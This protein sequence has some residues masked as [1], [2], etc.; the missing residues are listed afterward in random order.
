M[1]I[2]INIENLKTKDINVENVSLGVMFNPSEIK[3]VKATPKQ[4]QTLKK[5]Y[6]GENLIKL[7]NSNKIATIDE[8]SKDKASELISK[9]VNNKKIQTEAYNEAIN[10]KHEDFGNR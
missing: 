4:I 1:K 6:I 7:L 8:L 9:I 3:E 2:N 5:Y 10:S